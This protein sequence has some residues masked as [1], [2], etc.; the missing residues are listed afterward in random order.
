M[1][2][3]L[4]LL[5]GQS[6]MAGRDFAELDDI[7][8]VPGLVMMCK[9]KKW[10]PA[11][12]PITRDRDFVGIYDQNGERINTADKWENV[13]PGETARR[14][15]G[16][17]P[18]RTFGKLL[19]Q[20]NPDCQVGLIPTAVGGTPLASWMPG[21]VD[22][23]DPEGHPYDES[24]ETAREALKEGEI[25]AVL[26][27][28]GESDAARKNINYKND[29]KTVIENF[30]RDLNL[31]ENIPFIMG[32]LADFYTSVPMDEV[33]RVNREMRELAA[34][35]KGVYVVSAEGLSHQGDNLHFDRESAHE[36]GRRYFECY[37][38]IQ[39]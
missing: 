19:L 30:R 11:V 9:D 29:M 31:D 34:G 39:K 20:S 33:V 27:H 10:R 5:A 37:S 38:K 12:E 3:L 35:V 17:G 32:E 14:A 13:E 22:V 23:S 6:N 25:V 16:V 2:H 24:I 7:T 28:Q 15:R 1:K 36:L 8:P 26:W 21:G 18:G 4:V